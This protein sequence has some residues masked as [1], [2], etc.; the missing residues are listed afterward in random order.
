[1]KLSTTVKCKTLDQRTEEYFIKKLWKKTKNAVKKIGKGIEKGVKGVV[2]TKAAD[3][4]KK[5]LQDKLGVYALEDGKTYKDFRQDMALE[6]D[7]LGGNLVVKG[8]QLCQCSGR[9]NLDDR[10]R[11]FVQGIVDAL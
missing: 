11:S 2:T 8:A 3:I 4:V 10:E 5:F 6:F 7:Q 9:R 1:M